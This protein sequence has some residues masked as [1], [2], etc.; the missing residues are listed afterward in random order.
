MPEQPDA[1][2]HHGRE[3]F[4]EAVEQFAGGFEDFRV[5]IDEIFDHG[6]QVITYNRT[7]G[8]GSGSGATFQQRGACV[9]GPCEM[10]PSVAW[11]GSERSERPSKPSA[12][13]SKQG[14]FRYSFRSTLLVAA[15]VRLERA[16]RSFARS[17]AAL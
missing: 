16:G 12:W 5:L 8:R 7:F 13:R 1:S 6:D 11:N 17:R 15:R 3:G 2:V 14:E 10:E 9:C 4:L